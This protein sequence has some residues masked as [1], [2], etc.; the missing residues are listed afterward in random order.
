[1]IETLL[2]VTVVLLAAVLVLQVVLRPR[3]TDLSPVQVRLDALVTAQERAERGVREEFAR[4]R[5]EG[6]QQARV[7]R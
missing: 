6:A 5:E 2:I 3:G 7:G 1:M 4:S